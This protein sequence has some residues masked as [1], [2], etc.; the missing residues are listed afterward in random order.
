[1]IYII[2]F[3]YLLEFESHVHSHVHVHTVLQQQQ[4]NPTKQTNKT[5]KTTTTT[6]YR[7]KQHNPL[8]FIHNPDRDSG[9]RLKKIEHC[10]E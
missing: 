1:M 9:S 4:Q 7:K 10:A 2:R 6:N 3:Q 5:A 8:I